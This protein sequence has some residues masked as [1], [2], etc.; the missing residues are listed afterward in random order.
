LL[1]DIVAMAVR[2]G[3]NVHRASGNVFTV[4]AMLTLATSAFA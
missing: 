2:K 4:V 1:T 3:G